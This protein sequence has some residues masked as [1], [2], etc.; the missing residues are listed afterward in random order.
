[1]A[2]FAL[3]FPCAA[4][5][6]LIVS[7]Q[8]TFAQPA[9]PPASPPPSLSDLYN[10]IQ[11]QE[12]NFPVP[13]TQLSVQVATLDLSKMLLVYAV[14]TYSGNTTHTY[15]GWVPC[16]QHPPPSKPGPRPPRGAARNA[17]AKPTAKLAKTAS[18]PAPQPII[19]HGPPP[20][21]PN[22]CLKYSQVPDQG[23]QLT[24]ANVQH[25]SIIFAITNWP[26]KN[27][28]PKV[29]I[30]LGSQSKAVGPGTTQ[31]QFDDV[32]DTSPAVTVTVDGAVLV[33]GS[34]TPGY[35]PGT[36]PLLIQ[37]KTV[38]AGA[39]TVP[40]L[41]ISIVYAPPVDP[42]KKN[43]NAAA[44]SQTTGN[45]TTVAFSKQTST[46]TPIPS[47]FQDSTTAANDM[48]AVGSVLSEIPNPYTKAIG[49]ALTTIAKGLGSSTATQTTAT[50][51]TTQGSLSILD[52]NTAQETAQASDGGPGEGDVFSYYWNAR[53]L[54][55]SDGAK[56]QLVFLGADGTVQ[57]SVAKLIAAQK[58]LQSSPLE[59]STR[60]Q[61]PTRNRSAH[62][63]NSTHS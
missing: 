46:Q 32:V 39:M 24:V 27:L 61:R 10:T 20:S 51:V 29:T 35:I 49:T 50:K 31:I 14:P 54:W 3:R 2:R 18:A 12:A 28:F 58:R 44:I 8:T 52:E 13:Q 55:Y 5:M 16:T 33:N 47:T 23:G 34:P 7:A 9:N 38:G 6:A 11:A 62:C 21:G 22:W 45:S 17:L 26:A 25:L 48:N 60:R 37:W 15:E 59:Q 53:L 56:I 57:A 19:L 36:L 43:E 63:C 4:L 41:P 1:M 40:V 42:Q 30:Q